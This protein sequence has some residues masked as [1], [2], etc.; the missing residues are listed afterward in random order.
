MGPGESTQ[1]RG[2]PKIIE[3]STLFIPPLHMIFFIKLAKNI[4]CQKKNQT[5]IPLL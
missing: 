5:P 1:I 4:T 2:E 3:K